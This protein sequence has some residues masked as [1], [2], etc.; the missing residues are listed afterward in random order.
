MLLLAWMIACD[1]APPADDAEVSVAVDASSFRCITDMTP[2][3]G[4]Y[5]DNLLGDLPATLA[6]AEAPQGASWPA[7]SLVQLVP[8]E[9][10]VK[11][12]PGFSAATDDWEF[13]SL[14]T[15]A[16]GTEIL[17][18]GA[19]DVVNQFGGNCADCH[20]AA[21]GT[22]DWICEQDH[23]CVPLPL[24]TELIEGIQ[25]GDARCGG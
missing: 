8:F 2:V 14:R 24:S 20:R 1:D 13:F 7:G 16:D 22:W 4:F 17:A 12:E 9:A 23:G 21:A 19:E 6:V 3:R 5:V 10:M 25:Q 18:R 15:D 11:R